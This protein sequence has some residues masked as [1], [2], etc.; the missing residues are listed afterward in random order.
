VGELKER[1]Q[2]SKRRRE[3][4]RSQ[5][6]QSLKKYKLRCHQFEQEVLQLNQEKDETVVCCDVL[7]QQLQEYHSRLDT[8]EISLALLKQENTNLK[9][10]VNDLEAQSDQH[11][12]QVMLWQLHVVLD[13]LSVA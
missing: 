9:S 8:D 11:K 3:N 1:L 2:M 7:Q 10:Q 5:A 4:L 12:R 6:L 13:T